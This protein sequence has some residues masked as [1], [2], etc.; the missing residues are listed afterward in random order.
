MYEREWYDTVPFCSN[1]EK[2]WIIV[3]ESNI[4]MFFFISGFL[5]K[6]KKQDE[7]TISGFVKK[8][9]KALL[10]PYFA[11]GTIFYIVELV[12][13]EISIDPLLHL[14]WIN[15]GGL[16]IAGALWFLTALFIT[17]V[18]YFFIDRYISKDVIKWIIV[19][20]ISVFGN[21]A[22]IIL[23]FTLPYAAGAAMVGVGFFHVGYSLRKNENNRL[24]GSILNMKWYM[25]G[26]SACVVTV[27]IFVNGYV[28]MRSEEY[29]IIPLF[30]INAILATLVGMNLARYVYQVCKKN[31]VARWLMGIG[32]D[33]IIYVCLN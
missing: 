16:P 3:I 22:G 28:N 27:L 29:G 30:W 17:E 25:W 5:F 23:P 13:M 31:M 2:K 19:I 18:L 4:S 1:K 15:T 6:H 33:S 7:V 9:A 12:T 14:L 32:R 10:I 11:F 26:I 8:K 20:I 24:V 21:L